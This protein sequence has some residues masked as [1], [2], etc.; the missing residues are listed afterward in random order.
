[1]LIM[2][3][4]SLKWQLQIASVLQPTVQNIEV[5]SKMTKRSSKFSYSRRWNQQMCDKFAKKKKKK[6]MTERLINYK[7]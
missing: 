4:Q 7:K 6:K 5:S 1:M 2:I 3:S